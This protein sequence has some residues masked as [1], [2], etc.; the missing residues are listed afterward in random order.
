MR[1]LL[2]LSKGKPQKTAVFHKILIKNAL[3]KLVGGN[4][5]AAI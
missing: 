1:R 5:F 4:D 2:T 3:D